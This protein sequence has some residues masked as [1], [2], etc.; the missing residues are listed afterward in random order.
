MTQKM[1][2]API[3]ILG[4]GN[5]L[6]RDEGIGVHV[7]N[8]MQQICLPDTI[9]LLDGGTAGADLL[10]SISDR[11]KLIVIDAL[12]ANVQPGTIVSL[13]ASDMAN[14]P[15]SIS[16]H[17]F[18]LSQTLMMAKLLNCSPGDVSIFAVKPHDVSCGIGLSPQMEFLIPQ[19][20]KFLVDEAFFDNKCD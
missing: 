1:T 4:I 6:L 7:I 12:D 2:K 9:E 15:E 11:K 13:T 10:D 16:L 14:E 20:I 3:L 18:G 5:I 19:I 8:A 17:E